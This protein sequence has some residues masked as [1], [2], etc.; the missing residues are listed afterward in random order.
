MEASFAG[1][2][3]FVAWCRAPEDLDEFVETLAGITAGDWLE[4]LSRTLGEDD[5]LGARK[6]ELVAGEI[7]RRGAG[8]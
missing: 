7:V 6:R 4:R 5:P 8:V 1:A 2:S 3:Q